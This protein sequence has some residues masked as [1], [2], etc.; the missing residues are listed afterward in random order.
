[1]NNEIQIEKMIA[2]RLQ[3][4]TNPK[5]PLILYEKASNQCFSGV[6]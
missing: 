5:F 4:K 1:M 6:Y 3:L 2:R